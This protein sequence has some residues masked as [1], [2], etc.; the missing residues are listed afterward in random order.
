MIQHL[1]TQIDTWLLFHSH[2]KLLILPLQ[3]QFNTKYDDCTTIKAQ[4]M[5]CMQEAL[6]FNGMQ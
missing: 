6:V 3:S 5:K 1:A 4:E 2:T